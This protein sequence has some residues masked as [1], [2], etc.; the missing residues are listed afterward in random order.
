MWV[1]NSSGE[2]AISR[3]TVFLGDI[4]V[5]W[6]PFFVN[7]G[8]KFFFHP[9]IGYKMRAGGY[10][11]TTTYLIG[12]HSKKKGEENFL[13]I[14]NISNSKK[15]TRKIIKGLYL[16]EPEA[17]DLVRTYPPKWDLKYLLDYYT[18]VGLYS[19]LEGNFPKVWKFDK[20]SF[21]AGLGFSHTVYNIRDSYFNNY[22]NRDGA[23]AW[24]L[25]HGYIYSTKVPIRYNFK[26]DT[27]LNFGSFFSTSFLFEQ[28]SDS[29]IKRDF[30]QRAFDFDW[31][32]LFDPNKGIKDF[33]KRKSQ[34]SSYYWRWNN[35]I[36]IPTNK[37][38]GNYIDSITINNLR[39]QM[40]WKRK[41]IDKKLYPRAY[42]KEAK[43]KGSSVDQK[44]EGSFF[45][46]TQVEIPTYRAVIS[47]TLFSFDSTKFDFRNGWEKTIFAKAKK[48]RE[49]E[50]K[51]KKNDTSSEDKKNIEKE[52]EDTENNASE[53]TKAEDLSAK[54]TKDEDDEVKEDETKTPKNIAEYVPFSS[55]KKTVSKKVTNTKI[56]NKIKNKGL[57]DVIYPR[58]S[59]SSP[60]T[61]DFDWKK[62]TVLFT[63]KI[64]HS[65]GEKLYLNHKK[66][67]R[68][69]DIPFLQDYIVEYG[70][71]TTDNTFTLTKKFT[72]FDGVF[73]YIWDISLSIK[74]RFLNN[75]DE[76][77]S[78]DKETKE[79]SVEKYT[80]EELS[81]VHT[82][83]LSPFK[84]FS[85]FADTT[86]SYIA[87]FDI[88]KNIFETKEAAKFYEHDNKKW[89]KNHTLKQRYVAKYAQTTN[90]L[91]LDVELPPQ[92]NAYTPLYSFSLDTYLTL[93]LQTKIFKKKDKGDTWFYDPLRFSGSLS[94]FKKNL[95]LTQTLNYSYEHSFM[96]N[97]KTSFKAWWF[98]FDFL[99]EREKHHVFDIKKFSFKKV[100][101]EKLRPSMLTTDFTYKISNIWFWRDRI[102]LLI[103][104][105]TKYTH[106]FLDFMK[107]KFML[108]SNFD[109]VIYQILKLSFSIGT[110]NDL[111]FLYYKDYADQLGVPTRNFWD[112]IVDGFNFFDVKALERTPFKLNKLSLSITQDFGGWVLDVVY[113]GTSKSKNEGGIA[114]YEWQNTLEF[115][116]YWKPI[117]NIKTSIYYR[118]DALSLEEEVKKK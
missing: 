47:G 81:N 99:A 89:W 87:G 66:W 76:L 57:Y 108:S 56:D 14:F 51:K 92:L 88:A 7:P 113:S 5:L 75:S 18:T 70:H 16:R 32:Q 19:A 15:D 116:I 3:A 36:K 85:S 111:M 65:L 82:V 30:F 34:I 60:T 72:A 104:F 83:T 20:L 94:F 118:D 112:D 41:D 106:A 10:I 95:E 35:T 11:N 24:N 23:L 63:Y 17:G 21:S 9:A 46:P 33:N 103:N 44:I 1:L 59:I 61:Y 64:N 62:T 25:D 115:G 105:N 55:N 4:P 107:T 22:I 28:Y 98:S 102:N 48:K 96:K 29:F 100:G 91:G 58:E 37:I 78:K 114:K 26:L 49:E 45:Y 40:D 12:K 101:E 71:L 69:T 73:S 97:V 86:I 67:K 50:E 27:K 53:D 90:T 109:F 38:V 2:W 13:D 68:P 77:S 79:K 43:I 74:R 8:D 31:E 54:S 93:S 6:F 84:M 42:T 80:K 39:I 110:Q 117:P 52:T